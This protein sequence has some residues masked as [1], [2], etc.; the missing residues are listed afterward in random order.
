MLSVAP[1]ILFACT[2]GTPARNAL[3]ALCEAKTGFD[4]V[5]NAVQQG[6]LREG[7]RLLREYVGSHSEDTRAKDV[8]RLL[9]EELAKLAIP[10]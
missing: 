2:S 3:D 9:E 4:Q 10:K 1:I 5:Q 7:V 8:L 6:D